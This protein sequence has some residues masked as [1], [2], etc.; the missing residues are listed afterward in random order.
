[1]FALFLPD[2][3]ISYNKTPDKPLL[4]IEIQKGMFF[5]SEEYNTPDHAPLSGKSIA[6]LILGILSIVFSISVLLGVVLG[7]IGIVLAL[8][9]RRNSHMNLNA[10][11][12]L[13]LSIAGLLCSALILVFVYIPLGNYFSN[14]DV[15]DRIEE[16]LD[17]PDDSDDSDSYDSNH[18]GDTED[19]HDSDHYDWL[20]PDTPGNTGDSYSDRLQD[21]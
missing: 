4:P 8:A 21:L 12:G 16:E 19:H 1:M 11:I 3:I 7:I 18:N 5:M 6:A 14:D 9:S 13:G 17:D 15:I 2:G 10:K 20:F